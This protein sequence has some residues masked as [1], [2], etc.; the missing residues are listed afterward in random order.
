MGLPLFPAARLGTL[1][2]RV[3][4]LAAFFEDLLHEIISGKSSARAAPILGT[5]RPRGIGK[6]GTNLSL[7]GGHTFFKRLLGHI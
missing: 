4:N 6:Q 2:I 3:A 7:Q 5:S 1:L